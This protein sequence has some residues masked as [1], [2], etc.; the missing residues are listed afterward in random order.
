MNDLS[1]KIE[2]VENASNDLSSKSISYLSP[3]DL[4][5][6]QIDASINMENDAN[7]SALLTTSLIST[8][9]DD[10][11]DDEDDDIAENGDKFRPKKT[12]KAKWTQEEVCLFT[13]TSYNFIS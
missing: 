7:D 1:S 12:E 4:T 10:D 8:E 11:D 6:D 9:D 2:N 13:C 3:A 5:H